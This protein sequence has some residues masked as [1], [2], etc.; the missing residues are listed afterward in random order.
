MLRASSLLNPKRSATIVAH[1]IITGARLIITDL[2]FSAL[3][4]L[5]LQCL[6]IQVERYTSSS[7]VS[8]NCRLP[9]WVASS[10]GPSRSIP[11]V[12]LR[13]LLRFF[14]ATCRAKLPR[15]RTPFY[16]THFFSDISDSIWKARRPCNGTLTFTLM[17]PL[18]R[19]RAFGIPCFM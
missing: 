5:E 12:S 19:S 15:E 3:T 17:L 1:A 6:P 4:V 16:A 14:G 18:E 11:S 2:V 13:F 9:Y 8:P 7:N 10:C